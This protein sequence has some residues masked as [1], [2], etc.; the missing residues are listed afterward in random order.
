MRTPRLVDQQRDPAPVTQ[1]GDAVNVGTGAVLRR[2]DHENGADVRMRLER[3][4]H[5][6]DGRWVRDLP[7]AVPPGSEPDRVDAGQDERRDHGLVHIAVH[8]QLPAGAGDGEHRGVDGDAGAAGGEDRPPGTDGVD[9][10][11]LGVRDRGLRGDHVG[12][13]HLRRQR[14]GGTVVDTATEPVAGQRKTVCIRAPEL[15]DRV[16]HRRGVVVHD[17]HHYPP[18]AR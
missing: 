11:R 3:G 16:K 4:G 2:I 10:Q 1:L 7:F 17:P 15:R 8:Q 14:R 9:E 6:F 13:E 12:R 5:V 18:R